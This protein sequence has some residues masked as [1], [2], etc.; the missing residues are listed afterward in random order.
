MI[1][2]QCQL[3]WDKIE[4]I[5]DRLTTTI[6]RNDIKNDSS[7]FSQN[8][9]PFSH[10]SLSRVGDNDGNKFNLFRQS[11]SYGNVPR[12]TKPTHATSNKTKTT[13]ISREEGIFF[14]GYQ[15]DPYNI[16]KMLSSQLGSDPVEFQDK[17]LT[18]F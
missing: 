17:L 14:V 2:Q 4:E 9:C 12:P 5:G 11:K 18:L 1:V 15:K 7:I 8:H 6:G 10:I 13:S 3:N 16:C